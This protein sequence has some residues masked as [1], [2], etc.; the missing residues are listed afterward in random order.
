M[1][2]KTMKKRKSTKEP[3][4]MLQNTDDSQKYDDNDDVGDELDAGEVICIKHVQ[5]F[6]QHFHYGIF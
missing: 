1:S 6:T 5:Y 4:V 3:N 2:Q